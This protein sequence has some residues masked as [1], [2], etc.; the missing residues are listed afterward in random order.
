MTASDDNT[1]RL[2]DVWPLLTADTVA[3]AKIAALRALSKDERASLFLTE[4][5]TASGQ[6][7]ATATAD[8]PGAMC[9]QLAGDPFDP[10]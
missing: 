9:D 1:A 4:A 3:Y 8:D 7:H 5:D 6:E 10:A 2:W